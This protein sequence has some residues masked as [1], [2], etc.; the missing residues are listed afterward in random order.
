MQHHHSTIT[1]HVFIFSTTTPTFGIPLGTVIASDEQ[2]QTIEQDIS[3]LLDVLP[4]KAF[5]GKGAKVGPSI[6]MTDDNSAEPSDDPSCCP[7]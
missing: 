3:M 4:E 7:I 1:T 5:F 6:F 2:Q